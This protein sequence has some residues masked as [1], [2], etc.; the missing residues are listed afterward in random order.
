MINDFVNLVGERIRGLRKEKG[1]TQDE[2]A[3]RASIHNRYISDVE[4]G[5]RNI[6]L[7]T[8]DK[9]ITALDIAPIEFFQ[10]HN[11]DTFDQRLDKKVILESLNAL[12][13]G[14]TIEEIKMVNNVAKE[15]LTTFDK[16]LK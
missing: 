15:V 4:R 8:L 16:T 12:L 6:T 2:L 14:R 13:V 9:I 11:I 5:E 10:F 3:E 1:Y 7:E